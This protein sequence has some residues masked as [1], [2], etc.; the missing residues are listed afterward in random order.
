MAHTT[1]SLDDDDDDDNVFV[2][3]IAHPRQHFYCRFLSRRTAPTDDDKMK[4]SFRC[5]TFANSNA[6][7][8][9]SLSLSPLLSN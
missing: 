5:K 1:T 7:A 4:M 3:G 2:Y 9:V 8:R 6:R